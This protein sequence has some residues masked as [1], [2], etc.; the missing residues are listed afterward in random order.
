MKFCRFPALLA[1]FPLQYLPKSSIGLALKAS[2]QGYSSCQHDQLNARS[3]F[4]IMRSRQAGPEY[5]IKM[6]PNDVGKKSPA[7]ILIPANDLVNCIA[8]FSDIRL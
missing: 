2:E 1:D 4:C 5:Q 6:I 7:Q 8:T 3:H